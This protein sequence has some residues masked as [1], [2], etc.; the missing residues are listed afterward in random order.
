[1]EYDTVYYIV[2]KINIKNFLEQLNTNLKRHDQLTWQTLL[3][4]DI[5][6]IPNNI[7]KK[8]IDKYYPKKS[9]LSKKIFPPKKFCP[10]EMIFHKMCILNVRLLKALEKS[11]QFFGFMFVANKDF[12][13]LKCWVNYMYYKNN[14]MKYEKLNLWYFYNLPQSQFKRMIKKSDFESI[15]SCKII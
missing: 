1:M 14:I 2:N 15:N 4:D 10:P 9:Y 5:L 8:C 12:G 11:K 13:A 7:P 3:T 6:N